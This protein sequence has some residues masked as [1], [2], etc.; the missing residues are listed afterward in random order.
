MKFIHTA[1]LHLGARTATKLSPQ[2]AEARRGELLSTFADIAAMADNIQAAVLIAGDIFDSDT[3]TPRTVQGFLDTVRRFPGVRFLCLPGN[4][5][6]EGLPCDTIPENL[7]VFGREWGSVTLGDTT[8]YGIAPSGDVPYDALCPDPNQK[9]VVLLHGTVREG[10][11]PEP[12][13]VILDRLAGKGI[14]YLALGH[15]H[16]HRVGGLDGRGIWAYAGTPEG[17]GMD[18]AG[19]CGVLILD[20]GTLPVSPAFFKT[21][22]RTIHRLEV[23]ISECGTAFSAIC[24]RIDEAVLGIPREDLVRIELLGALPPD[25]ARPEYTRLTEH[26]SARFYYFEI[27]DRTR[28]AISAEDYRDSLTL[29]GEFVRRVLASP[30]S[31][32]E[33][34][35]IL[36]AGFAA[37]RTEEDEI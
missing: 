35:A 15:Y 7:T 27:K 37:L 8:V 20:T 16:S 21:A 26:Y 33:K 25:A 3:P 28:I 2:K 24:G 9:N 32:E 30:L 23:D 14:D 36:R 31:E 6:G 12:G 13:A 18:E 4:H 10:G 5:D 1:D 22:R 19:E 17:R 34:S 29:K 11:T